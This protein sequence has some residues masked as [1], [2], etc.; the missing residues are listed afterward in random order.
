MAEKQ[1][2]QK[3]L[4]A[5][6][7]VTY[8][9]DPGPVAADAILAI[10]VRLRALEADEVKREYDRPFLGAR[11]PILLN[12]R[13]GLEFEVEFAGA[14]AAGDVP[15]YGQLLRACG[16]AQ[17]VNA[18]VDVTYK[19]VSDAFESVSIHINVDG[20]RHVLT[21]ARGNVQ[22]VLRPGELPRYAFNFTGIY[23]APTDQ[24]LP[25]VDYSEFQ[26]PLPASSTNTPTVLLHGVS[27]VV[28]GLEIDL[29]QRVEPRFLLNSE[30]VRITDREATG[31]LTMEAV[32]LATFD[33][34][35]KAAAAATGTMQIVHGT[36]AGNIVQLDA[37]RVQLGAPDYGENQG[38]ANWTLP[39]TLQPTDAGNDELTITIK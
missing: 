17:T 25:T 6:P 18:G 11:P 38:V 13:A 29:G 4:L 7:E 24:A 22:I 16:M 9:T 33:P 1:W 36:A 35:A 30:S 23:N 19:P 10:N 27:G 39:L 12:H 2:K 20:I 3:A 15:G 28:E 26:V 5:V 21:G 31:R 8:G 34:F 14:G 37:P 32:D